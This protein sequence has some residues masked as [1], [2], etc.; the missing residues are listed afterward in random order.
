MSESSRQITLARHLLRLEREHNQ[1]NVPQNWVDPYA[2]NW[3]W[4]MSLPT[5]PVTVGVSEFYYAAPGWF[6]HR[7]GDDWTL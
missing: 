1:Q 7:I 6:F 2:N 5:M 4:G 3:S